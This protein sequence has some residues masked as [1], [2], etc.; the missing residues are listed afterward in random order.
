MV[1]VEHVAHDHRRQL[2]RLVGVGPINEARKNLARRRLDPVRE[3]AVPQFGVELNAG[4]DGDQTIDVDVGHGGGTA[5]WGGAGC[6]GCGCGAG[7]GADAGGLG[8]R[9]SA[10]ARTSRSRAT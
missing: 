3:R 1:E 10:C 6:A 8:I 2:W 5:Y 4:D 7:C 9:F